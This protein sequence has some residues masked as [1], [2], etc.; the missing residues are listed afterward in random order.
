[1]PV[2]SEQAAGL[3]HRLNAGIHACPL[4]P[5]TPVPSTTLTTDANTAHTNT[6]GPSGTEEL[7]WFLDEFGLILILSPH[8]KVVDQSGSAG[9]A[10]TIYV[11]LTNTEYIYIFYYNKYEI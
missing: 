2:P 11:T 4:P 9:T 10:V 3:N 7:S 6:P 8:F 5:P 1:M